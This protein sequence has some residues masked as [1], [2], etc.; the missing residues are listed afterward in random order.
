M[1]GWMSETH[2][3]LEQQSVT[4]PLWYDAP[5]LSSITKTTRLPGMEVKAQQRFGEQANVP[6]ISGELTV[7]M[8]EV[9]L[10]CGKEMRGGAAG[11]SPGA[12][13]NEEGWRSDE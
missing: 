7:Y 11:A 4:I 10:C 9:P 2:W 8:K 12:I 13:P 3:F 5:V 1:H 6:T